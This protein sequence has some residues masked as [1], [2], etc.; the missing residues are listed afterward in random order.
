ML[1]ATTVDHDAQEAI[2]QA[3][4]LNSEAVAYA[5]SQVAA[6]ASEARAESVASQQAATSAASDN[7]DVM[8]VPALSKFIVPT[9]Y[10]KAALLC[11]PGK[12]GNESLKAVYLQRAILDDGTTIAR[13]VAT[14]M[15]RFLV[16]SLPGDDLP[17]WL[18]DGVLIPTDGLAK[19]LAY[20]AADGC[21]NLSYATGASRMEMSDDG[22]TVTFKFAPLTT[23]YFNIAPVMQALHVCLGDRQIDPGEGHT[24][25]PSSL[26]AINDVSTAIDGGAVTFYQGPAETRAN[27]VTFAEDSNA[28]MILQSLAAVPQLSAP[29]KQ[30]IGDIAVGQVVAGYKAALTR[31]RNEIAKCTDASQRAALEDRIAGLVASLKGYGVTLEIEAPK[32]AS[33]PSKVQKKAA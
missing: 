16:V 8:A 19:R 20:L 17:S 6:L 33:K 27:L 12:E 18:D 28:V 2:A 7:C 9:R 21:A 10:L 29:V 22:D 13:L 26:K 14:D 32:P 3:V 15:S 23:P 4:T 25:T 11:V 30:A 5:A 31:R 1:D 24:F